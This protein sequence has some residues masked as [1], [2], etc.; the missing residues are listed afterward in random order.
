MLTFTFVNAK[1]RRRQCKWPGD[2]RSLAL[3]VKDLKENAGFLDYVP[4][5]IRRSTSALMLLN[6]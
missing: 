6:A 2:R 5:I 1:A 4:S 3:L